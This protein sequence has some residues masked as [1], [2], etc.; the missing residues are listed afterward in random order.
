MQ[1][2]S[3]QNVSVVEQ[4]QN[5]FAAHIRARAE[6]LAEDY[7]VKNPQEVGGFIGENFFLLDILEEIP[8]QI[9]KYFG[10]DQ[11]LVLKVSYQPDYPDSAELWVDILTELSANEAL[12]LLDKF[13]E[14]WWLENLDKTD[15]KLNINLKFV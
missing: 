5:G 12:P 14:E 4:L 13:D 2:D 7:L 11:R 15:C 10:S 1:T 9:S 6:H 3:V 8:R